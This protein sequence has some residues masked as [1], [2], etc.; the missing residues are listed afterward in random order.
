[1]SNNTTVITDTKTIEGT[2]GSLVNLNEAYVNF[3]LT[4]DEEEHKVYGTV[5]IYL[6]PPLEKPFVGNVTGAIYS[7][8]Y[9]EFVQG[10]TLQ[11]SIPSNNPITPIEF[12]FNA[13]LHLESDNKGTGSFQFQGKHLEGLPVKINS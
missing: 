1:M 7:T 9:G 2:L 6:N 5:K 4:L 11:G 10:I 8:G 12:L 13:S 3:T